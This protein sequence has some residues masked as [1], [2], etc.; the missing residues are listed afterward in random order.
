M[1]TVAAKSRWLAPIF[2]VWVLVA[3]GVSDRAVAAT[4]DEGGGIGEI[5][6]VSNR[7]DLISGGDALVSVDLL[8]TS[9]RA[10][11]VELNGKDIKSAFAV[12]ANG[13]FEGLVTG[14]EEGKN[15]L[16]VRPGNGVGRWIEITNHPIGGP[17][18]SGEQIQPWLCRTQLQG[19]TTPA[20]GPSVDEKCNAAAPVVE[21]FYR[22]T[23]NQ[24]VAYN[25]T[26]PPDAVGDPAD[27]DRPGQDGPVHHPARDGN[28]Q[29][30][31]LPDRGARRSDQADHAVVDRAAVEPQVRQH[32]RRRL[33]RQLPAADGR[34]RAQRGAPGS[35]FRGRHVQPQHLRQLVQ[36]RDLGR[37]ADDDEGDHHRALGADRLHDRRR[38]LRRNDAA[39]HD[40]RRLPRA[41]ERPHDEPALRGPLVPGRRL[42]RLPAAVPLLRAGRR[43]PLRPAPR[44]GRRER[45][46]ALPRRRRAAARLRHEP[47][48][49]RRQVLAED[50]LH[51]RGADRRQHRGLRWPAGQRRGAGRPIRSARAA[52]SRTT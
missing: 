18:F 11:R 36:R 45:Q 3:L 7:A 20:L 51:H 21:L 13:R 38:W 5:S 46:P 2:I 34:R 42:V 32:L 31:H 4:F 14:L 40:L 16:R 27:D 23:G 15:I 50:R 41:A 43:R 9:P 39:A 52:R 19:G 24:W 33:Q 17:V 6:V 44:V 1:H 35:R 25:P 30:R 47:V 22:S 10:V 29:P 8:D 37:G 26:S 12:R 49:S 48:Q 28:G